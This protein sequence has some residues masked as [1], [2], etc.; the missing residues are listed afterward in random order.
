MRKRDYQRFPRLSDW[1]KHEEKRSKL[2]KYFN[3]ELGLEGNWLRDEQ[4]GLELRVELYIDKL[5]HVRGLDLESAEKERLRL[6]GY[7]AEFED[8]HVEETAST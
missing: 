7:I 6:Y 4:E 1:L 5:I 2:V 8:D 3:K